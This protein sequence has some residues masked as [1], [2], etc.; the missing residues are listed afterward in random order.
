MAATSHITA[1]D[2]T[3][4]YINAFPESDQNKVSGAISP[5]T[6]RCAVYGGGRISLSP[7]NLDKSLGLI[8]DASL[9]IHLGDG[10]PASLIKTI[11]VKVHTRDFCNITRLSCNDIDG[12]GYDDIIV[13]CVD[14]GGVQ[15]HCLYGSAGLSRASSSPAPYFVNMN[16]WVPNDFF[17]NICSVNTAFG[18]VNG[19]GAVDV[20]GLNNDSTAF[21]VYTGISHTTCTV[22]FDASGIGIIDVATVVMGE[23]YP[24]ISL[25]DVNNDGIL[26]MM[27][28][29]EHVVKYVSYGR[30][31]ICGKQGRMYNA[32]RDD[33]GELR[34]ELLGFAL[35]GDQIG[36]MLMLIC[37]CMAWVF[38]QI[39][40]ATMLSHYRSADDDDD[41]DIPQHYNR[42]K[43]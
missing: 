23:L 38:C 37:V 13:S 41:D 22:P 7:A 21:Y 18:D 10:N 24:Q 14:G 34:F 8:H 35:T 4:V 42:C 30:T 19:D 36:S 3:N 2:D 5:M 20:V 26:D 32:M 6:V 17:S 39:S 11:P 33:D 12:D 15:N 43:E 16:L 31:D 29:V 40:V 25:R 1:A 27:V 9:C 28:V